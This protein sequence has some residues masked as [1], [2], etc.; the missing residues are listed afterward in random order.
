MRD[1]LNY[2]KLAGL[3]SRIKGW[4]S[5]LRRRIRMCIWK[6]WKRVRTRYR[7]L[8]KLVPDENRVRMAAFCRKMYCG[9]WRHILLYM[10]HYLLRNCCVPVIRLLRCTI[11]LCSS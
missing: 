8:K 5:W 1:W 7:N 2:F 10:K 4:D 11:I 6:S 3:R 9:V